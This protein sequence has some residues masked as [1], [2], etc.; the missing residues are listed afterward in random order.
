MEAGDPVLARTNSSILAARSS[1]LIRF[2]AEPPR[3]H[4]HGAPVHGLS[5]RSFSTPATCVNKRPPG[6]MATRVRFYTHKCLI[7]E[8]GPERQEPVESDPERRNFV[9][10]VCRWVG[11]VQDAGG[12]G[13]TRETCESRRLRAACQ[14]QMCPA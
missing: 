3:A 11:S 5:T 12:H 7:A 14:L 6:R 13:A 1:A 2:S 8:P 4:I 9:G 10:S